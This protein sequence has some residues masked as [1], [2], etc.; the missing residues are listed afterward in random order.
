MSVN[1][2]SCLLNSD[3]VSHLI[4][5]KQSHCCDK[6]IFKSYK[7]TTQICSCG[8]K[9]TEIERNER[10]SGTNCFVFTPRR[11]E[12]GILLMWLSTSSVWITSYL[13]KHWASLGESKR[14]EIRITSEHH[15]T[16]LIEVIQIPVDNY[17]VFRPLPKEDR[18]GDIRYPS[19]KFP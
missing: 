10:V 6:N 19:F 11:T 17:E 15:I 5:K 2:L 18:K 7:K 1:C 13:V 8:R 4:Q 9:Q 14:V 3:S 16:N 12:K